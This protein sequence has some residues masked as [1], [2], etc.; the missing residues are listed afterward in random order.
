MSGRE[1]EIPDMFGAE[2]PLP[3]ELDPAEFDDP[4]ETSGD[5]VM[6]LRLKRIERILEGL[7]VTVSRRSDIEVMHGD[8]QREFMS[9]RDQLTELSGELGRRSD[10]RADLARRFDV[11]AVLSSQ[12]IEFGWIRESLAW[13]RGVA[14]VGSPAPRRSSV[15]ALSLLGALSV[16][17]VLGFAAVAFEVVR[18]D[19]R[20]GDR[21]Q[22]GAAVER[23]TLSA[24][25]WEA[26]SRDYQ[27]MPAVP[28][29]ELGVRENSSFGLPDGLARE[30]RRV[31][32]PE[33]LAVPGPV[34]P[35]RGG[36]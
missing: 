15:A 7:Q 16:F 32:E 18:V 27:R 1:G 9:V 25:E 3:P 10:E 2:L 11:E 34:G 36:T 22:P 19:I 17:A 30:D 29:P 13:L 28:P 5:E 21:R 6:A 33:P 24:A 31:E 8:R 14:T 4:L 12:R 35:G 26:L 23:S 20:W